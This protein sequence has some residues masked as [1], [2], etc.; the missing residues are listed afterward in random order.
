MRLCIEYKSP[1]AEREREG[2]VLIKSYPFVQEEQAAQSNG[3]NR[4]AHRNT[5][6]SQT[7]LVGEVTASG[8][9]S[10]AADIYYVRSR[11]NYRM[12]SNVPA[13]V[14][15]PGKFS[16]MEGGSQPSGCIGTLPIEQTGRTCWQSS[17]FLFQSRIP[18]HPP[19][20]APPGRTNGDTPCTLLLIAVLALAVATGVIVATGVC[21]T[22]RPVEVFGTFLSLLNRYL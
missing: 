21:S 5:L 18:F 14:K 4:D 1:A 12:Y 17:T 10:M 13:Q 22:Q 2:G 3:P 8:P 20:R 9:H 6:P 16:E 15:R 7:L 19:R 11:W